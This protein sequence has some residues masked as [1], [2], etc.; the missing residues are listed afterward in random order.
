[1]KLNYKTS[2][3]QDSHLEIPAEVSKIGASFSL[4][5]QTSSATC[6]VEVHSDCFEE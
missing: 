1:M 4:Y 2:E 5:V 6:I 3:M